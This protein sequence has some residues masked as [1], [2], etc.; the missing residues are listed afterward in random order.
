MIATSV[1]ATTMGRGCDTAILD[2]PVSA[3]QAVSDAE[4][5]TANTWIDA[6]LRSRLNDP[7]Q[8]GNHCRHA[9]LARTRRDWILAGAGAR[10]LDSC[11]HSAGSGGGRDLDLP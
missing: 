4:R 3:D 5:T 11:S 6:T 2:G 7:R 8:G 1:G 9:T 10:G